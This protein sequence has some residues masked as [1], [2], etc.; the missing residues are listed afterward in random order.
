M[1][2][3]L[4]AVACGGGR[5]APV[6]SAGVTEVTVGFTKTLNTVTGNDRS[7]PEESK[8]DAIDSNKKSSTITRMTNDSGGGRPYRQSRMSVSLKWTTVP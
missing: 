8:Y 1:A 5:A 6:A 7:G 3:L 2:L 4:G